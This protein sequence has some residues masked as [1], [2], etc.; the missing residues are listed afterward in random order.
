MFPVAA[1]GEAEAAAVN[2]GYREETMAHDSA[3]DLF[4][5]RVK[6][7]ARTIHEIVGVETALIL[8]LAFIG[9]GR[10]GNLSGKR[11]CIGDF[12]QEYEPAEACDIWQ[13]S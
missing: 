12:P 5:Y 1:V 2:E 13:A 9:T 6:R 10:G 8:F 11:K 7:T 3:H 4:M